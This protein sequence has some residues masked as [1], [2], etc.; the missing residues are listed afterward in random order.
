MQGTVEP[1]AT[2]ENTTSYA[3]P[4]YNATGVF[5]PIS[6]TRDGEAGTV[7]VEV[8]I[9]HTYKGDLIVDLIHPDGTVYNLQNRSGG[10]ANDIRQTFSVDVGSR[11]ASG[12]WRLRVRDYARRDVGTINR[13]SITFD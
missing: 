12:Q 7:S 11:P 4:D 2:F 10:S 6:V 1:P 3:I 13:W 5:S 8:D 9:S